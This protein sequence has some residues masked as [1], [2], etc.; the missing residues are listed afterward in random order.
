MQRKEQDKTLLDKI[1]KAEKELEDFLQQ[2][3]SRRSVKVTRHEDSVN[4]AEELEALYEELANLSQNAQKTYLAAS[5]SRQQILAERRLEWTDAKE[6]FDSARPA[7]LLKLMEAFQ[8]LEKAIKEGEHLMACTFDNSISTIETPSLPSGA[9]PG[10]LSI[11]SSG[12]KSDWRPLLCRLLKDVK[13]AWKT[14]FGDN[15][16]NVIDFIE[17]AIM[18][19]NHTTFRVKARLNAIKAVAM[20]AQAAED[21]NFMQLLKALDLAESRLNEITAQSPLASISDVSQRKVEVQQRIRSL[22]EKLGVQATSPDQSDQSTKQWLEQ[23]LRA[24]DDDPRPPPPHYYMRLLEQAGMS[25]E[26][27]MAL[28]IVGSME[29][30]HHNITR[31]HFRKTI[32]AFKNAHPPQVQKAMELLDK[33]PEYGLIPSIET[34]NSILDV[35]RKAGSWRQAL[36][37]FDKMKRAGIQPNTHSYIIISKAAALSQDTPAEIYTAFQCAGIPADVCYAAGSTKASYHST[38]LP[39]KNS[40]KK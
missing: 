12:V 10:E 5:A 20:E 9:L 27:E 17:E 8:V 28:F 19:I 31:H 18:H 26:W 32:S 11:S 38:A 30:R 15:H 22:E 29:R 33:M 16:P 23:E 4:N 37:I 25:G 14:R 6:A 34:Y 1:I 35:C 3:L 21:E 36:K 13:A 2:D 40:K 7:W 39:P 24:L